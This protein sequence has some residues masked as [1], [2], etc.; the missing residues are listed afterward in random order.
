MMIALFVLPSCDLQNR[1]GFIRT[2]NRSVARISGK[3]GIWVGSAS[4]A[5]LTW[6]S[7]EIRKNAKVGGFFIVLFLWP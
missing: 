1:P 5:V 2:Q 4:Q 3:G 7:S 6:A